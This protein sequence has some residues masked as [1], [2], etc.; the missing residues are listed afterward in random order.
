MVNSSEQDFFYFKNKY[1]LMFFLFLLAL[2]CSKEIENLEFKG[3]FNLTFPEYAS[4]LTL[5]SHFG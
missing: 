5:S 1:I 2:L 4:S 3:S